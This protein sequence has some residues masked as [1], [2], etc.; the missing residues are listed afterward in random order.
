MSVT[1]ALTDAPNAPISVT[2]PVAESTV[3]SFYRTL[4]GF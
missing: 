2:K 4:D 1:V 3:T